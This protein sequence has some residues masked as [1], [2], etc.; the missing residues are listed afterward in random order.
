MYEDL[1]R[2]FWQGLELGLVGL[3]GGACTVL[4]TWFMVE[5][6]LWT[7]QYVED[8]FSN[9]PIWELWTMPWEI[10]AILTIAVFTFWL[11]FHNWFKRKYS[12]VIDEET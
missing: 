7:M 8:T 3:Y 11:A 6:G 1:K 9:R 5:Q 2:G 12:E 10:W 4:F